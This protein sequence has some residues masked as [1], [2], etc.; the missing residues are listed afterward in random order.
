VEPPI[1]ENAN[2]QSAKDNNKTDDSKIPITGN[3]DVQSPEEHNEDV[4]LLSVD[5]IHPNS[6]Q[7]HDMPEGDWKTLVAEI[8]KARGDRHILLVPETL[9]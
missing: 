1:I 3:A 2:V 9:A 8:V 6:K 7:L 4:E 5:N